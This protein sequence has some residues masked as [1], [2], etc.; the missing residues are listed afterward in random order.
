MASHFEN[1]F[2]ETEAKRLLTL[3]TLSLEKISHSEALTLEQHFKQDEI[4]N[5]LKEMD[6]AKSP[7]PDG[8]SAK[9]MKSMWKFLQNDFNSILAS[10]H[11]NGTL[12]K[13]INSSFIA[14]VPK[15]TNLIHLSDF[16]LI[17]LINTSMKIILKILANRIKLLLP[18][19]IA[20]E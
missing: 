14:L 1:R 13:G 4:S 9:Y 8:F 10:F 11:E 7:G 6:N 15:I 2:K 17:S 12:S 16:R 5:A 20:E 18:K 19:L 3:G